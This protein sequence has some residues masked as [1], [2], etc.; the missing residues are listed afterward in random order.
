MGIIF[1]SR[2][3]IK[4][5]SVSFLCVCVFFFMSPA[6]CLLVFLHYVP[7]LQFKLRFV[8]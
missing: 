6:N 7:A 3:K 4:P 5:S 2:T 1:H 8:L